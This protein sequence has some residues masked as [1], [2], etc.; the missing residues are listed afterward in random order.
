MSMEK[1]FGLILSKG[2][3]NL[4][5]PLQGATATVYNYG[6]AV[7]ASLF[8]DDESTP[9]ANPI[10]TDSDG[11]YEFNAAD[12][13]YT[14]VI[15]KNGVTITQ[16][17]IRLFSMAGGGSISPGSIGPT[18]LASTAV[19]P[20]TY[21]L[22][23]VTID[24]DGRI[25]GASSNAAFTTEDA[26]DAVGGILVDS[27]T[28]DFTYNDGANTITAIVIDSSI[29]NA[30][31]ANMAQ[32][33]VSGRAAGAG[34]G[35]PTDLSDAQLTAIVKAMV[36]DSGSGGT[37]GS[38]PAP[39]A[40]DAAALKFLKAD[41]TWAVPASGTISSADLPPL[42]VQISTVST[43]ASSFPSSV[44]GY[45]HAANKSWYL[46]IKTASKIA[47][48]DAK[49]GVVTLLTPPVTIGSRSGLNYST[50]L[51][52]IIVGGTA[53]G[54]CLL[55]PSNDTFGSAVAPTNWQQTNT[56]Y[57]ETNDWVYFAGVSRVARAH[58]DG[59]T[60][61]A[62]TAYTDATGRV[63]VVGTNVFAIE[64]TS[65]AAK[66]HKYTTGSWPNE[67]GSALNLG[68]TLSQDSG[69]IYDSVSGHILVGGSTTSNLFV[70]DPTTNT[71]V[72]TITLDGVSAVTALLAAPTASRVYAQDTTGKTF[73]LNAATYEIINFFV[74]TT[75]TASSGMVYD[76]DNHVLGYM[77]NGAQ[78]FQ[79][80]LV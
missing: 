26:E 4:V 1:Y 8:Q 72:S 15:V 51:G 35:V 63:L 50:T 39:A 60:E 58:S 29:T 69:L 78:L 56:S 70:V 64:L 16:T 73:V 55:D 45:Y 22:A 30:K 77:T 80:F 21:V 42:G 3:D 33:T 38:V 9:I 32:S 25:T 46:P 61:T 65:G 74:P 37:K 19:T 12:G 53:A 14:I 41:G 66:L 52:K 79:R 47:K 31:R 5:R 59:T 62:G 40:G 71:L 49:S 20:G 11:R 13:Q 57:D 54:F 2:T 10:T 27:A 48:I 36:G 75:V 17:K 43:G 23:T 28:I 68:D 44:D 18:E 34:T 76:T 6:T 24:A 67:S 7:L